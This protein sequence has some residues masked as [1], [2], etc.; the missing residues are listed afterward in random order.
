MLHFLPPSLKPDVQ[1]L[2]SLQVAW[3]LIPDWIK[4]RGIT[5]LSAKQVCLGPVTCENMYRFCREKKTYNNFTQPATAGDVSFV[6][7]KTHNITI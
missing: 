5:S 2:M 7:G 6:G 1:Q 4:L 3:M